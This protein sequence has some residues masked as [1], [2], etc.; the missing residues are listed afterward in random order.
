ML[1]STCYY[2]VSSFFFFM[3][4]PRTTALRLFVQLCPLS[5]H[6]I[7]RFTLHIFRSF[8]AISFNFVLYW[9]LLLLN[10]SLSHFVLFLSLIRGH[11]VAQLVEALRYKQEGRDFDSR[12]DHCDFSLPYSYLPQY[13]PGVDSASNINDYQ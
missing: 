4:G 10:F 7:A 6:F 5:S 12:W 1:P 3:K 9:V 13:G 11:M 8:C 2:V